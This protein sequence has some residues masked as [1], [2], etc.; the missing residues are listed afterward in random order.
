M[1]WKVILVV[2]LVVAAGCQVTMLEPDPQKEAK[3][4]KKKAE[5]DITERIRQ[6]R[7]LQEE[8]QL[9]RDIMLLKVEIAKIQ[10]ENAPP[11]KP[12]QIESM[13]YIPLDQIPPDAKVSEGLGKN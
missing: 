3:A 1:K 13:E 5:A 9:I 6:F 10:A 7:I 4:E 11:K 12:G 2:L 8:Q